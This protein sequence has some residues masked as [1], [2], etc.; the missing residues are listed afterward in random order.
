MTKRERWLSTGQVAARLGWDERT[1][2][3]RCESGD[4][5]GATRIGDDGHWRI[6][7]EWLDGVLGTKKPAA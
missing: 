3:R 1:I 6:P 5:P 7:G 4:I 2:R